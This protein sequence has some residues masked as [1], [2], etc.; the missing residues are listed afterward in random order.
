MAEPSCPAEH[1][2]LPLATGETTAAEVQAHVDTCRDCQ[3]RVSQLRAEVTRL[4]RLAPTRAVDLEKTT[5]HMPAAARTH[6]PAAEAPP[7]A[8]GRYVIV[9]QLGAGGQA[10]VYR[11]VH[12]T[13]GRQVV[14]KLAVHAP[15]DAG[16]RERLITEGKLLANLD[17]PNIARVL[18]LDF[19]DGRP[20]LVMEYVPGRDLERWA[21]ERR[22]RPKEIARLVAKLARALAAA[23]R[24]GILHHDVKPRN[25]LIDEAG[26]PRLI[27][28]GMA[29]LRQGWDEA[30][31][32]DTVGGTPAYMAP[33][34]ARGQVERLDARSD[35][36]ALGGVL[37][38]L[39][40]GKPPFPGTTV[41]EVLDRAGR[42][43]IDRA[44]LQAAKPPRVLEAICLKA[45]AAEPDD[46]YSQAEDMAAALERFA[47]RRRRLLLLAGALGVLLMTAGLA[48]ALVLR[49][50]AFPPDP[51]PALFVQRDGF[52][53]KLDAAVPLRAGD[54]V[55]LGSLIPHGYAASLFW[56]TAE[57]DLRE[58]GPAR[59][60]EGP[61][62]RIAYP[63][64]QA[65]ALEGRGGTELLLICATRWGR[66]A[67]ADVEKAL[68][69]VGPPPTLPG[70]VWLVLHPDRVRTKVGGNRAPGEIRPDATAAAERWLNDLRRRLCERFRFVSG[71]LLP[72]QG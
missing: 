36:F 19:H 67:R 17:H 9:E 7:T 37:F 55:R 46:R 15:D 58:L 29:R 61:F 10:R 51:T 38:F 5:T 44:A 35:V 68:A 3:Q 22:L 24:Q 11:A 63:P 13:L 59:A 43:E 30:G 21:R 14:V 31:E 60:A 45:L 34:Q 8:V 70:P 16:A 50:P 6:A 53:L 25:V 32:P 12:P 23:H 62:D 28:F 27:D 42:C 39:L 2:L 20:F 18:D 71:L 26:Q 52:P 64:Q 69:E 48:L 66:P 56:L 57:G 65:T 4:R 40:T 1:D 33:E 41:S 72:Y 54:T 47:G 49:E